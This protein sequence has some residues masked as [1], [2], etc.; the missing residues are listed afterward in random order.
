MNPCSWR[1][2]IY[3]FLA[4]NEQMVFPVFYSFNPKVEAV[5]LYLMLCT[6]FFFSSTSNVYLQMFEKKVHDLKKEKKQQ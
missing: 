2:L 3:I 4:E 5:K 6:T 1:G